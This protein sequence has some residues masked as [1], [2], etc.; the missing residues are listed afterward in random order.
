[1]LRSQQVTRSPAIHLRQPL[2]R[3][4][5]PEKNLP[6]ERYKVRGFDRF[7]FPQSLCVASP[8]LAERWLGNPYDLHPTLQ[9]LRPQCSHGVTPHAALSSHAT[10]PFSVAVLDLSCIRGKSILATSWVRCRDSGCLHAGWI[11]AGIGH[12]HPLSL[13]S[14]TANVLTLLL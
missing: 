8:G 5:R 9:N 7:S 14:V 1:M 13:T 2:V 4:R 6:P 10:A 11:K 12:T 3:A